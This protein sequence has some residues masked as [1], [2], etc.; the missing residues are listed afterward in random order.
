MAIWED[1]WLYYPITGALSWIIHFCVYT[2]IDKAVSSMKGR[3]IDGFEHSS[4]IDYLWLFGSTVVV[5]DPISSI[6]CLLGKPCLDMLMCSEV[7]LEMGEDVSD[8]AINPLFRV[9]NVQPRAMRIF[10]SLRYKLYYYLIHLAWYAKVQWGSFKEPSWM[11]SDR[12]PCIMWIPDSEPL[13]RCSYEWLTLLKWR[14]LETSWKPVLV[15]D[16]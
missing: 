12:I 1:T 9:C 15:D 4:F 3:Q 6:Q 8:P 13:W 14:K 5:G 16:D 10:P 7:F 2:L 11:A